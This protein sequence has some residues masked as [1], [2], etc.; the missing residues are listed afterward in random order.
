MSPYL[1]TPN[2]L[3]DVIAAVQTL[4][5]YKFYKLDAAEWAERIS[6]D[7][8]KAA[9]WQTIFDEHPEFFRSDTQ[10]TRVSLV[11]RRQYPKRY[12]VDLE[13]RLTSQ[14]FDEIPEA[15]R[16]RVSRDPLSPS[17]IKTLVDTAIGLHSRA[18][19][20]R[21]DSRWWIPL[22]SAL[23]GLVGSLVGAFLK[24]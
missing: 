3:T 21:R 6:G 8:G 18:L 4:A 9:H 5:T 23:G 11:W 19:E 10:R 7:A 20:Q 14:E 22:A 17:D 15:E 16:A 1:S 13:R 12:H 24:L 2:R